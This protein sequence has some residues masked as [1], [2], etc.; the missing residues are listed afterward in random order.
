M[1]RTL[2]PGRTLR[3]SEYTCEEAKAAQVMLSPAH[4]LSK[5]IRQQITVN[6][7]FPVVFT[8]GVFEA[9]NPVLVDAI[10]QIPDGRRHRAMAF[11]DGAVAASNPELAAQIEAYFAAHADLLDLAA[12]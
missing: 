3:D 9:Q 6:W 1:P 10:N 12:P 5:T 7:E 4:M 11:I 8:H 2:D